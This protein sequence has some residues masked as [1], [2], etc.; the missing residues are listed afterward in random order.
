MA[1]AHQGFAG[2]S[3]PTDDEIK[4]PEHYAVNIAAIKTADVSI[5]R[6]VVMV[7]SQ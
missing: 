1:A 2:G 5:I 7:V 6:S 4:G 3:K